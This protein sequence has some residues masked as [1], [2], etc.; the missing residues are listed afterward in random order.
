MAM[1][2]W[3]VMPEYINRRWTEEQFGL[4]F[5]KRNKRIQIEN[6]NGAKPSD[7]DVMVSGDT[8]LASMGV[9]PK[10]N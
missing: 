8:F 3:G 1:H 9:V 6:G 7:V 10:V 4:L 5:T 2:D